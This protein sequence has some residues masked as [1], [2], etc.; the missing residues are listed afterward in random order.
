M[1]DRNRQKDAR[2]CRQV[3]EKAK[4]S[5]PLSA[6]AVRELYRKHTVK[7]IEK[8]IT[9]RDGREDEKPARNPTSHV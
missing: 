8:W 2:T 9:A 4:D 6:E 1:D 5:E 3:D 7:G